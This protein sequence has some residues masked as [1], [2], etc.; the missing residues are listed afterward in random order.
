M[1]PTLGEETVSHLPAVD[2]LRPRYHF[3]P[4]A[5][6]M[7][8]PNAP[9]Y[10]DGW[11][12]L[13][14]QH[15]PFGD[16]W[17][18]VHWGHARS[19]DLLR[20]EHLPIAL[21]PS[22]ELGEQHCFSGCA[23]VDDQGQV[24]LL[25]TSVGFARDGVRL[26]NQ[27]WAALG[28]PDLLEWQ[29]SPANPVLALSTHDGPDVE[30]E[31]RDPFIFDAGVRTLLVLAA[32]T[33]D[34]ANIL[35]Y[36]AEGGSLL[37]WRYRSVLYSRPRTENGFLECP[38]FV[39][40]SQLGPIAQAGE[41]GPKWL[42]LISPYR[43]VEYVVGDFDLDT[44]R[45][46]PEHEGVL[47]PGQD[48]VPNFYAS[49]ILVDPE[50]RNIL[51]GWARGFPP[52]RGWNGCLTLPR[53]LTL[54]SDGLPRQAPLPALEQL[55][56]P[57]TELDDVRTAQGRLRI[58]RA[59]PPGLE[60]ELNVRSEGPLALRLVDADNAALIAQVRYVDGALEVQDT[61]VPLALA[62]CELLQLRLFLDQSLLEVFAGDDRL[63]VTRILERTA[64]R[65]LVELLA[66]DD[67]DVERLAVWPLSLKE[68]S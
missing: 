9:L 36:E 67:V 2:P 7:N 20:W 39:P 54:G 31:W 43:C 17:G 10:H 52:G 1:T 13:F 55:R 19:R 60:V 68:S 51:L 25:Y 57:A 15:N 26:P 46:T 29:K 53:L 23:G 62:D 37:R 11:Y 66:G 18:F 30:G 4:P 38:N 47:D 22:Y 28:S 16:T 5:N 58:D 27:Q 3:L 56:G 8:D 63:A 44:L 48:T 45:F 34:A 35:L 59:F 24:V 65:L 12:H 40:I 42:L 33:A 64:P 14:Y 50:G 32:N 41:S 6:W 49:N 61:V 21:R